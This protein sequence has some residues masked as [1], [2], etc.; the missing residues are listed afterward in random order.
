MTYAIRPIYNYIEKMLDCSSWII[1]ERKVGS[2]LRIVRR[3]I[4]FIII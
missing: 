2:G 4:L 3:V 1:K